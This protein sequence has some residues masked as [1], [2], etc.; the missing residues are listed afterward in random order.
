MAGKIVGFTSSCCMAAA[1][2]FV[3][4]IAFSD[5]DLV[6]FYDFKDGTT[7]ESAGTIAVTCCIC[8]LTEKSAA[9]GSR[10]YSIPD[11]TRG[12]WRTNKPM[13][14]VDIDLRKM[15]LEDKNV[16]KADGQISV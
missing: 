5:D 1:V 14:V 7:G 8:E 11:F 6:A 13:D 12:A 16:K 9:K 3:P 15:G 10:P 4:S 2:C